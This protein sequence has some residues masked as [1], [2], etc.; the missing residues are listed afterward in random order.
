MSNGYSVFIVDDDEAIR[1]ALRLSLQMI[2]FTVEVYASGPEFLD[3]YQEN[4]PGCLLLDLYMPRMNGLEVQ[5]E[6]IKR[7]AR[8][9][10]IFMTGYCTTQEV[11]A[12][13]EAGAVDFLNKPIPKSLLTERIL[14]ALNAG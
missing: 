3:K 7:N 12:A 8:I 6:L 4:R 10:I 1:D 11:I 14:K 9:P 5:Q 13:R 2:G